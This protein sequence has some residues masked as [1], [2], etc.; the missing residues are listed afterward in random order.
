MKLGIVSKFIVALI[1][2]GLIAGSASAALILDIRNSGVQTIAVTDPSAAIVMQ[3]W[4][5]ATGSNGVN[6]DDGIAQVYF[7]VYSSSGGLLEGDLTVGII[8]PVFTNATTTSGL[9]VDLDSDGD[10]D[11]GSKVNTSSANWALASNGMAMLSDTQNLAA[12]TFLGSGVWNAA[13]PHGVTMI[14]MAPRLNTTGT[15]WKEDGANKNNN[16]SSQLT[17]TQITLYRPTEAP[18]P[19]FNQGNPGAPLEFKPLEA[20][21]MLDATAGIGSMNL[22]AWD[23]T[24]DGNPD[25]TGPLGT[26]P[27]T[28]E[29]LKALGLDDG[30]HMG[31]LTTSYVA[32]DPTN[33]FNSPFQFTLVPEPAT[34]ALLGL[35]GLVTLIRR[36]K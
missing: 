16:L 25:F 13:D 9:R 27:L 12:L 6:T 7:S 21:I 32:S 17:G 4:A 5:T 35:G 18:V 33:V 30:T 34:L 10:L 8:N 1:V 31:M 22:W 2:G 36:K 14:W 29:M 20:A 19:V 15:I 23:F 11:V 3:L 26:L 28:Y 24:G